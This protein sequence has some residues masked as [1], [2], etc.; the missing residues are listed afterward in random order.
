MPSPR[1]KKSSS[2]WFWIA[3][4]WLGIGTVNATQLVLGMHLRGMRHSWSRLF[5]TA[6]VSWAVWALASPLIV[7]LGR[8]FPPV[9]LKPI[10]VWFIH[11]FA[12]TTIRFVDAGWSSFV[13]KTLRPWGTY[14]VEL[15]FR[16]L[17]I[18]YFYDEFHLFIIL[19]AAILALSYTLDSKERLSIQETEAARLNEQLSKA[20]LDALRRQLE[21]HFLFNSLNSIAA[22]VREGRNDAAVEMV[23]R[24][25]DLLRRVLE[26]SSQQEVSLGEEIEFLEKYLE[27]QQTRFADR[28]QV[29]VDIPGE[30]LAA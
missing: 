23:V 25:G 4:A 14:T 8:Q 17:W 3:F 30:L 28:L 20:Q 18:R 24:L 27:I 5:L 26:G 13:G 11:L 7:K 9:R 16:A 19:Y 29:R 6:I 22:L 10:K 12:C 2:M 1:A 21:P 15:T